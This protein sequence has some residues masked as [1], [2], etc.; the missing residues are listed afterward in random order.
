MNRV[1]IIWLQLVNT[2]HTSKFVRRE[3]GEAP[4]DNLKLFLC[5]ITRQIYSGTSDS[6]FV[7]MPLAFLE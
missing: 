1:I 2:L 7:R 6:L 3:E 5:L 4:C